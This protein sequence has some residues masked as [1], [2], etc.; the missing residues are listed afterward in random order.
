MFSKKGF[1]L[2]EIL[3]VVSIIALL[4]GIILVGL[5]GTRARG[6]DSRRI[7]DLKSIQNGLGL[8]YVKNNAYP[9]DY[10]DI[11]TAGLGITKLPS[12]PLDSAKGYLYVACDNGQSYVLGAALEAKDP[13]D[14]IFSDS[15]KLAF[16]GKACNPWAGT[17]DAPNYCVSQ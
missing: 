13:A 7:V 9:A 5:G 14:K 6:R 1:T 12:D 16:N 4:A 8:Y 10:N 11:V 2:I 15:D 17:C 3:I